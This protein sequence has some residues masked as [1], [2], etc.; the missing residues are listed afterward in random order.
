MVH[1][2][3]RGTSAREPVVYGIFSVYALLCRL[4]F[5]VIISGFSNILNW[6]ATVFAVISTGKASQEVKH[7][8]CF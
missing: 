3:C 1:R 6:I 4:A 5:K 2:C 8:S 7:V